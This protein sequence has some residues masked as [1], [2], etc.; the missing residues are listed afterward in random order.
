MSKKYNIGKLDTSFWIGKTGPVI[1]KFVNDEEFIQEYR[2]IGYWKWMIYLQIKKINLLLERRTA[3]INEYRKLMDLRSEDL[4]DK[5]LSEQQKD[6]LDNEI[7]ISS[8]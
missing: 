2:K 5:S 7:P 6:N 3:Y 8:N 1:S 4:F